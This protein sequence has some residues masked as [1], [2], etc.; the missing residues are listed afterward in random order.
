MLLLNALT[1]LV[2]VYEPIVMVA[3][4]ASTVL[5]LTS[6]NA[7]DLENEPVAV[8][9]ALAPVNTGVKVP[10]SVPFVA[11]VPPVSVILASMVVDVE[12]SATVPIW[13][14]NVVPTETLAVPEVPVFTVKLE[15]LEKVPSWYILVPAKDAA[16]IWF[17]PVAKPDAVIRT[18]V[19]AGPV[20]GA[21][22]TVGAWIVNETAGGAATESEI[23]IE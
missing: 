15:A 13:K 21:R 9:P 10:V 14:P 6:A 16:V 11:H 5:A 17:V 23:C 8:T 22:V 7:G 2:A 1:L 4:T 20:E 3:L 12:V 19:P 18:D